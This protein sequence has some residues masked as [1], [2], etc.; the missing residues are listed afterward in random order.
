MPSGRSLSEQAQRALIKAKIKPGCILRM[1]CDFIS[2]P[3]MKFFVVVHVDLSDMLL[4]IFIINSKIPHF[5]ENNPEL[6]SG[7]ISLKSSVYTFLEHDS[8]LNCVELLDGLE[9]DAL[10][11]HLLLTP[12]DYKGELSRD[13]VLAVISAVGDTRTISD[14]DKGLIINSLQQVIS[15]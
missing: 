3:K 1:F 13:D 15:L 10:V 9:M 14:Y 11:D 8:V 4:L 6:K 5:I 12:S 2:N 7:Q